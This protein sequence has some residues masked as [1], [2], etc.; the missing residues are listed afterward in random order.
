MKHRHKRSRRSRVWRRTKKVGE[1]VGDAAD[2]ADGCCGCLVVG[3]LA[4]VASAGGVLLV[5]AAR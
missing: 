3:P 2:I 5:R 1:G 4:V